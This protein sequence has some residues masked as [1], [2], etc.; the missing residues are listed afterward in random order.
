MLQLLWPKF[1]AL[2]NTRVPGLWRCLCDPRLSHLTRT[3]T[4][5]G[6][7]EDLCL[8]RWRKSIICRTWYFGNDIPNGTPRVFGVR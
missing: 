1:L 4:F 2:A 8:L 5:F 6:G 7:S 3:V